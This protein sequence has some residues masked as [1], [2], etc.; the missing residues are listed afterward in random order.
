MHLWWGGSERDVAR[1]AHGHVNS[2]NI[3]ASLAY[4]LA[5]KPAY[6][7]RWRVRGRVRIIYPTT[8]YLL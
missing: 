1:N 5:S 6:N 4:A 7:L 3:F 8:L 2:P